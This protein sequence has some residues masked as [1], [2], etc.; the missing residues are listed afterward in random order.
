MRRTGQPASRSPSG[1]LHLLQGAT[2][3]GLYV[4][5]LALCT[6]AVSCLAVWTALSRQGLGDILPPFSPWGLLFFAFLAF[7]A[8]KFTIRIG[9]GMEVSAAFLPHFLSGA[10]VGPV[11]SII[12]ALVGQVAVF[13]RRQHLKNLCF[14]SSLMFAA[15]TTSLAYWWLVAALQG[16]VGR[17]VAVAL[18]GL[19]GG[20]LFQLINFIVFI[21]VVWIRRGISP[22]FLWQKGFQPFLP[23]HF[24]F[25]AIGLV[26]IYAA[27]VDH[28]HG[29]GFVH[30]LF[31]LPVIGLIY[32]FRAYAHQRE[33]AARN[34]RLALQAIASQVTALDLKDN[35][36]A[37]HSAAVAQWALDIAAAMN[38]GRQERNVAH[39]AGLVHDIGKIGVRDEVLN[40]EGSLDEGGWALIEAHCENGRRVLASMD[41]FRALA[42]V[43]LHHHERYDG[44][45]YPHGLAGEDIPLISR[46][47]CV[48]DSYSAMVSDRP[49][50]KALTPDAA[51]AELRDKKGTQFDP[52]V[53]DVF[54]R[55]LEERDEQYR[56]GQLADFRVEFQKVRFLRE[57]PVA[58]G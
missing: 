17:Q 37:Q 1:V 22:A 32:A 58:G 21:P 7:L 29:F 18:S 8:E 19:C 57:L 34:E 44:Q 13:E 4:F 42:E 47:I 2:L 27:P 12:V 9:S 30:I 51:M 40:C 25:L 41:E 45:G 5:C 15:G 38:L 35:Y 43:V 46:I 53:V 39:L 6:A 3:L 10:L 52:Q 26:L 49:Y 14:A 11:S 33:M 20:V 23:Y 55:L 56:R 31:L 54:L 24:F 50:R 28:L 48:A 36:T 16:G